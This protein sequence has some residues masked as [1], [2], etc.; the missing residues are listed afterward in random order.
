MTELHSTHSTEESN[1]KMVSNILI[2]ATEVQNEEGETRF[3]IA[4]RYLLTK[5]IWLLIYILIVFGVLVTVPSQNVEK[6]S[7]SFSKFN[8]SENPSLFIHTT[9]SHVSSYK[10]TNNKNFRDALNFAK[11][12]N[13]T[14]IVNSGD[15]VDDWN[16]SSKLHLE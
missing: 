15:L 12:F 8:S 16:Y 13:N 14:L 1:S 5:Y 4:Y 3:P 7:S 10:Q 2:D 9:D 6:F 11:S